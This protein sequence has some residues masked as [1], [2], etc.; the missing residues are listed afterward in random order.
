MKEEAEIIA[1]H[2]PSALCGTRETDHPSILRLVTFCTLF[3]RVFAS[4]TFESVIISYRT[5]RILRYNTVLLLPVPLQYVATVQYITTRTHCH[6]SRYSYSTYITVP[7][8][9]SSLSVQ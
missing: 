9:C 8:N 2:D 7:A 5:S 6:Y 1:P 3:V 4:P